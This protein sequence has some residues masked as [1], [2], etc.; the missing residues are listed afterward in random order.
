MTFKSRLVLTAVLALLVTPAASV[1]QHAGF[2]AAGI[3]T[4]APQIVTQPV[5]IQFNQFNQ[6]NGPVIVTQQTARPHGGAFLPNVVVPVTPSVPSMSPGVA[7]VQTFNAFGTPMP[8]QAVR[9]P[10][11]GTPR[12]DVIRV[13]GQ[14][15]ATVLTRDREVLYF[16][17]G[18][19]ILI[20][21]GQVSGPK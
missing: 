3:A 21:N 7:I 13:L 15:T 20:E 5:V 18:V 17:G 16:N 6:F 19:T 8:A 14:P 12:A 2:V 11:A 9:T 4:A 10:A 1:A